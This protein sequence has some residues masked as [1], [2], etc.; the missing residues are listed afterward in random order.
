[1]GYSIQSIPFFS[2]QITIKP[3]TATLAKY[4][5]RKVSIAKFSNGKPCSLRKVMETG[6]YIV[7]TVDGFIQGPET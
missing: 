1:M 5:D 4:L 2:D 3:H 7:E 6:E